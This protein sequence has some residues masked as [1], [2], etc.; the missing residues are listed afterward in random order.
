M[1]DGQQPELRPFVLCSPRSPNK[2]RECTG[3]CPYVQKTQLAAFQLS[4]GSP[5][6]DRT[7]ENSERMIVS[8]SPKSYSYGCPNSTSSVRT[9]FLVGTTRR[10]VSALN[11]CYSLW[12]FRAAYSCSSSL[13]NRLNSGSSR[14][15]SRW[16]SIW[17]KGQHA[18][19]VS[20]LRSSH[21]I[22]LSVSPSTA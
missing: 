16:G 9:A 18:K 11:T 13:T 8:M 14:R 10:A 12:I 4:T 22:A 5:R 17:K 19:P 21:A 20:T 6:M 3:K 2:P 1:R 15:L 7:E